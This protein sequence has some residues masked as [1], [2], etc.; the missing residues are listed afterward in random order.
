MKIFLLI[1]IPLT[2]FASDFIGKIKSLRNDVFVVRN[3]ETLDVEK[4]FQLKSKDIIITGDKS[5]AKVVF[6]DKTLL[7]VGKNS[8]FEI[9]DYMYDKTKK[10]RAKFKAKYGFF[11]AVTGK[12]SPKG[13]A[14][15]TKTA[16]IGVRGTA[17]EGQITKGKEKVS[18]T[19][20]TIT[21][22]AKGKTFVVD[23]GQSLEIKEK[24]F[25][26]DVAIVGEIISVTGRVFLIHGPHTFVATKGYQI[27]LKDK[28]ITSYNSKAVIK[29]IDDTK[30]N[31]FK[32]SACRLDYKNGAGKIDVLKGIAEL[33]GVSEKKVLNV[34][35]SV[36]VENGKF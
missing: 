1:F 14:L 27:G 29:L 21:V 4:G 19:K 23:A 30:V 24:M 10:S 3:F 16:T 22:S 20:G 8:I 11:S 18:C 9:E 34:G 36:L 5:K 2:I 33:I 15:K 28:I 26:P 7:T 32:N 17:F 35:E 31:L 25:E 13:F 6:I 12:I